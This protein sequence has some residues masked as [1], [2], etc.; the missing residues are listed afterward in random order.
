MRDFQFL[1]GHLVIASVGAGASEFAR[2]GVD[3]VPAGNLSAVLAVHHN[4]AV[5]AGIVN[6]ALLSHLAPLPHIHRVGD[7]AFERDVVPL[8]PARHLLDDE[9]TLRAAGLIL[10]HLVLAAQAAAFA[11]RAHNLSLK[12]DAKP[13]GN[14]RISR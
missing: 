5:L 11:E 3:E 13:R 7:A 9:L 8:H 6:L 12:L 14:Y 4:R 10:H 2:P 1:D